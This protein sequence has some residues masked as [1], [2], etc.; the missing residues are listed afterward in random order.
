MTATTVTGAI[1]LKGSTNRVLSSYWFET[2]DTWFIVHLTPTP[3]ALISPVVWLAAAEMQPIPLTTTTRETGKAGS[4]QG[5]K[6]QRYYSSRKSSACI[7]RQHPN[8]FPD[9]P[10]S[11]LLRNTVVKR[12]QCH[13]KSLVLH[14]ANASPCFLRIRKRTR[15]PARWNPR[16]HSSFE[17]N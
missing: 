5:S 10:P 17:I 9:R 8:D 14:A 3:L 1:G 13:A 7:W 15:A 6:G 12:N 2:L 16:Q 4:G 11:H